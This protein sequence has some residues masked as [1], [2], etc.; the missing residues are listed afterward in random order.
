MIRPRLSRTLIKTTDPLMS[1]IHIHRPHQLGLP[2]ARQVAHLW[3]HKAEKKFD[4]TSRY[5][6]A[7]AQGTEHDTLHFE[8]AGI[9]G[10]MQVQADQFVLTA[11]L[12]FLFS[13]FKEPLLAKLNAQFD[14]LLSQPAPAT[15]APA[16]PNRSRPAESA[17]R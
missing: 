12:G 13:A 8:N 9:Q 5:E 1:D 3:A 2:A 15:P 16:A 17:H 6:E 10:Q 11:K 7:S 4:V 14:E